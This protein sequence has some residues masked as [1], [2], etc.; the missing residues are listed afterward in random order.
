MTYSQQG[1]SDL[2]ACEDEPTAMY[3]C[4]QIPGEH[5]YLGCHM[6]GQGLLADTISL[7]HGKGTHYPQTV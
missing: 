4:A 3:S 2:F 5:V 1:N 6:Q 7:A